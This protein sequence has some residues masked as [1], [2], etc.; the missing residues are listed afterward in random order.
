MS[1]SHALRS[2]RDE[3]DDFDQLLLKKSVQTPRGKKLIPYSSHPKS[4][5]KFSPPKK[6]RKKTIDTVYGPS[7]VFSAQI[8]VLSSL[9][10]SS[11]TG[12]NV[13]HPAADERPHLPPPGHQTWFIEHFSVGLVPP[14]FP[15]YTSV[16][17][18]YGVSPNQLHPN[19]IRYMTGFYLVFIW[20]GVEPT[21]RQFQ[22]CF[23]IRRT[24]AFCFYLTAFNKK[25]KAFFLGHVPEKVM[26]WER[27][28]IFV[29]EPVDTPFNF[30]PWTESLPVQIDSSTLN[31]DSQVIKLN[32]FFSGGSFDLEEICSHEPL[33]AFSG[34][35]PDPLLAKGFFFNLVFS[36][37]HFL[38][39]VMSNF[40][41]FDKEGASARRTPL[42]S[43]HC[44]E[45]CPS[46]CKQEVSRSPP[47]L[48]ESVCVRL[49][50]PSDL[51]P[52]PCNGY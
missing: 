50:R 29:E 8:A 16:C 38:D 46:S 21:A 15:F 17:A 36:F 5:K 35:H 48:R 20:M 33:L 2:L 25:K 24:N 32:E 37:S 45:A 1:S 13:R 6:S 31:L 40:F 22:S 7:K 39:M 26:A 11:V 34:I 30:L 4:S 23:L 14:V 9:L 28:C 41:K 47:I 43:G 12:F 44:G 52:S 3:E 42:R 10:R 49:T 18:K 19:S 27:Y 51:S